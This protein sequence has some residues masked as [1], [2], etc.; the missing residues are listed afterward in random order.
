MADAST[1]F[2]VIIAGGSLV[3]LALALC[4]ERA[5]IEYE[6][7][8]KGELAPQLG[9]SIGWHPHGVRILEQ[10][11]L[12]DD[13][14]KIAV[15]LV[16]RLIFDENGRCIEKSKAL[17][18]ISQS[19]GHPMLFIERCEML[20][21]LSSH[22]KKKD[23]IHTHCS[24]QSYQETEKGVSVT[25]NDGQVVHGSILVGADGIHSHVRGLMADV[26]SKTDPVLAKELRTGFVAQY[27]CVFGV[28]RNG[29]NTPIMPD[30]TTNTVYYDY[31]SI[32]TATGVPGLIFWF[33]FIKLPA[34][35]RAPD[36]PRYSQGDM[37]T[38]IEEFGD[39]TIGPTYTVRDLWDLRVKASM[40]PLEEGMLKKWSHGR[41]VLVG[42]S[43]NKVTINAGLG[44][45]TAYEGIVCFTNGLVELLARSPTPSLS[46]L[47][48]VFQEFEETHR[49]RADTVT[50]LSGL[51]TRYESQDTWYLKLV[52]RWLS[53]W[54]SDALK[55]D[56]Y[57]SFFGKA[58]HFN[59]LPK[60]KPGV[61]VDARL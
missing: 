28:S 23:R 14:E 26:I 16:D 59:W 45:N 56:A 2:K 24:I 4:F 57:V 17:W 21:I 40:A 39:K 7:F 37:E 33:L 27:K 3:G 58:P 51:I 9:A 35:V 61:V 10:L 11:G 34:P 25:T 54:L 30:A 44:G 60:P 22:I 19:M 5:G 48:A 47:T 36:C 8:E 49:Q 53:P 20:S 41:V 55:T 38:T 12:R 50:W 42:D 18:T 15:P 29:S 31:Y 43:I 32:L 6:L 13:I 52:S 1:S 46:E